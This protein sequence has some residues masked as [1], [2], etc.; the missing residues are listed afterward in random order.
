M[1]FI[2]LYIF[3]FNFAIFIILN[4]VFYFETETG[5]RRDETRNKYSSA[6]MLP[7]SAN[8]CKI[9]FVIYLYI[10]FRD[11]LILKKLSKLV[12]HALGKLLINKT[13]PTSQLSLTLPLVLILKNYVNSLGKL[14]K[15]N[16][17]T[18]LVLAPN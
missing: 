12:R 18:C 5:T 9:L 8:C 10:F 16:M 4:I 17:G 13:K 2:S 6:P 7:P 15:I 14:V 3:N 1:Y 11:T